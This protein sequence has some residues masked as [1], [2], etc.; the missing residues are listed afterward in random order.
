VRPTPILSIALIV[1]A[2]LL[3][4]APSPLRAQEPAV[5]GAE[6]SAPSRSVRARVRQFVQGSDEAPG[7]LERQPGATSAKLS[8]GWI[9]VVELLRFIEE[10]TGQPVVY[11]SASRDPYFDP[12]MAVH[13]LADQEEFDAG[14]ARFYLEQNG[15]EFTTEEFAPERTALV[16]NHRHQRTASARIMP[17]A[18][19]VIGPEEPIPAAEPGTRAMLVCSLDR[20]SSSPVVQALRELFALPA[21]GGKTQFVALPGSSIVVAVAPV[22]LLATIR[23]TVRLLDVEIEPPAAP[24]EK[25]SGE[26]A[27]GG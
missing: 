7:L 1:A 16:V 6:A 5:E 19:L 8:K 17:S 20:P 11:P 13:F 2:G 14:S 9:P 15:F 21:A 3:V 26:P 10:V 24:A 25:S 27:R 18:E 22:E 4:I 12:E 23:E